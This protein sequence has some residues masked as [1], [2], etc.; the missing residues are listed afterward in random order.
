MRTDPWAGPVLDLPRVALKLSPMERPRALPR[1]PWTGLWVPALIVLLG[2]VQ[3]LPHL[4]EVDFHREEGR[5]VLPAREMLTSGN[6][7]LPTLFGEPYLNKPPGI[8]WLQA[9]AQALFGGV[10]TL[11]AR[12]VSVLAALATLLALWA[13]GRRLFS[14]RAG[15]LAALT[16]LLAPE[17]LSKARL[18]EIE[19][20]L[21]LFTFL[22]IVC[23]WFAREGRVLWCLPAGLCLA[24]A[25]LL[26]GP[27]AL[28]FF[29]GPPLLL[30]LARREPR[31]LL[32]VRLLAVLLIGAA[33]AGSWVWAV[34]DQ[35]GADVASAHWG[36]QVSGQGGHTF[37]QYLGERGRF[38]FGVL[39]GAAPATLVLVAGVGTVEGR[40]LARAAGGQLALAAVAAGFLFFLV[41][42]GTSVRYFF[43]ALPFVALLAGALLDRLLI[44]SAPDDAS[45]PEC[46]V[47]RRRIERLGLGLSGLGAILVL[48][49]CVGALR[50]LGDIEI[51]GV[52]LFLALLLAAAVIAA[53]R[54]HGGRRM[55]WALFGVPLLF[56]HVLTSQVE[57]AKA[58]RHSRAPYAAQLDRRL[59]PGEVLQLAYHADYNT[60]L[61]LEHELRYVADW[62]E[63]LSDGPWLFS[64]AQF[65]ELEREFPG[66]RH[67]APPWRF[68]FR[69]NERV[70]LRLGGSE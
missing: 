67:A 8:F 12:L 10:S 46:R 60:L 57:V 40:G 56:S 47:F 38:L 17:V 50:P 28:V 18:A 49:L 4:T 66:A 3:L 68:A 16:F 70:F 62:R 5:R 21:A 65:V 44:E 32:S 45:A 11:A 30:A 14:A 53:L 15:A 64:A 26:K 27:A 63:S 39:L 69:G 37:G 2:L 33:L 36:A 13:T 29:L 52:G 54:A 58:A 25:L 7:V 59:E 20:P 24:A 42:P 9:A 19:A 22:A 43:P 23:W 6:W 35:V 51:D 55:A 48:S 31:V 41:F 34:F 61:Y 1:S